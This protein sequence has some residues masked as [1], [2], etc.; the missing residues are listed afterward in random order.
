MTLREQMD[1]QAAGLPPP[2]VEGEKEALTLTVYLAGGE[3][4]VFAWSRFSHGHLRGEELIVVFADQE[5]V[6]RGQNLAPVAKRIGEF[7]I[8]ILRTVG[9]QYR[10]LIPPTEPFVSAIEVRAAR[11]QP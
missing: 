2:C 3:T 11:E 10:V 9:A 8:E 5:I 7:R 1:R 4:W 6:L